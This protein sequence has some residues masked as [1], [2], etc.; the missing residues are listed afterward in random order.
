MLTKFPIFRFNIV[1]GRTGSG[2]SYYLVK[3][4]RKQVFAGRDVCSS[5]YININELKKQFKRTLNYRISV[6]LKKPIKMG[7]VYLFDQ[8]D[9]FVFMKNCV[10]YFDEGHKFFYSRDWDKLP[11]Y[12]KDKIYNHRKDKIDIYVGVQDINTLDTILRRLADNAIQVKSLSSFQ[13][14]KWWEVKDIDKEKKKSK[15]LQFYF[16]VQK[17]FSVFDSFEQ[18]ID[19]KKIIRENNLIDNRKKLN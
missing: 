17:V 7:K 2:K 4:L 11:K 12:I 13:F 10:V 19:F 15:R 5:I 18:I 8:L 1:Y 16:R 9:D 6:L 14:I 3:H